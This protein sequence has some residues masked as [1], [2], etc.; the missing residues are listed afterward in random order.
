MAN[1]RAE[2]DTG[3]PRAAWPNS[4]AMYQRKGRIALQA[5]ENAFMPS[6]GKLTPA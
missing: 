2:S 1:G 6:V 5:D 3:R 4:T